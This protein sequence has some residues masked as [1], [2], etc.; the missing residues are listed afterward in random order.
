MKNSKAVLVTGASSG[1]GRDC[2]LRLSAGGFRVFAGVRRN[3]DG[4]RLRADSSGAIT[5][6]ILDV[7][8]SASIAAAAETVSRALDA[9]G[10]GAA[11]L[12]GLVN[13]AGIAVAGPLEMLPIEALRKQL[14]VNVVGQIAVTQAF[15]PMLRAARG[16]IIIMG[17]ILGRMALPFVGAYSAAKFALEALAESLAMEIRG[18]GVSVSIIEPGNIATPIW[19]K[20]KSSAVETA[21]DLNTKKW[22]L[23]R[24][25]TESFQRYTDHASATGIP[26]VR[27]AA[28]VEKALKAGRARSRYT[29]GWDSRILGRFAPLAPGRLRQWVVLKVVLRK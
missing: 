10:Q 4:E 27:V 1:I 25:P 3:E 19:K 15:L 5:P 26:P 29:V 8:D 24:V 20:S 11:G 12:Y 6:V 2:T 9:A 21:G 18:S 28:V 23:Y 13:N 16:R 14:D 17:S 22:D 7:T